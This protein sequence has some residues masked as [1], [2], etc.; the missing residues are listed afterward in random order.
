MPLG[1]HS[2]NG[3]SPRSLSL[4]WSGLEED[5]VMLGVWHSLCGPSC[6]LSPSVMGNGSF[7]GCFSCP[8]LPI[9]LG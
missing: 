7:L 9:C 3:Y 1:D 6:H 2:V 4:P 5:S 8:G